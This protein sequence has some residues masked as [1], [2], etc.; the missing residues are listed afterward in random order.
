MGEGF[1]V[2]FDHVNFPV[3]DLARS[4]AFY[5]SALRMEVVGRRANDA[6]AE[7][8]VHVGWGPRGGAGSTL[9]LVQ[10]RAGGPAPSLPEMHIAFTSDDLDALAR[11]W[12]D[13]VPHLRAAADKVLVDGDPRVWIKDP[14]GHTIEV[15]RGRPPQA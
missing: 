6:K 5:E 8:V 2:R 3:A 10:K 13:S 1:S 11:H 4:I 12:R 15:M 9:E 14:D 7:D